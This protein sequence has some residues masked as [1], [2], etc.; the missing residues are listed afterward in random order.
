M[1][2]INCN[3]LIFKD[4]VVCEPTGRHLDELEFYFLKAHEVRAEAQVYKDMYSV[5]SIK[6]DGGDDDVRPSY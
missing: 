4:V 2:Q 6:A 5:V 3:N 1:W